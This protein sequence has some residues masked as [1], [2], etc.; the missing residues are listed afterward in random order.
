M[1]WNFFGGELVG[2]QCQGSFVKILVSLTP[3]CS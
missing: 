1:T 3:V 2:I